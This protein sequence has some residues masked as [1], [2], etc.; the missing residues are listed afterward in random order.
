MVGSFSEIGSVV[1]QYDTGRLSL[2]D[3]NI[4]LMSY[5]HLVRSYPCDGH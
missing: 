5:I 4:L 3:A 1:T 2:E